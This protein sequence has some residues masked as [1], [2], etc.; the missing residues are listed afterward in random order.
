LDVEEERVLKVPGFGPKRTARL[1]QWRRTVEARFVFNAA[2][3]IPPHEQ[4]ALDAKFTQTRQQLEA[5]LLAGER[6]LR[7]IALR[8]E[9]ELRQQHEHIRSCLHQLAQAAAD[10]SIVPDGL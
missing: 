5:A 7:T 6:E 4:Q 3:G 8:V 1:L 2:V 9:G 10:L